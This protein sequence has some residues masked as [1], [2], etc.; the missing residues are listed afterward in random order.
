MRIMAVFDIRSFKYKEEHHFLIDANVWLDV[1]GPIP[2][3]RRSGAYTTAMQ[4]MRV[5]KSKIHLDVLVLSEFIN[6][7]ARILY[8]IELL[9][10]SG[11]SDEEKPKY[12]QFRD[13]PEFKLVAEEIRIVTKDIINM[14]TVCCNPDFNCDKANAFTD[15][16]GR[17]CVDFNDQI[18]ADSCKTKTLLLVTDDGDFQNY[19]EISIL[20][21]NPRAIN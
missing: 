2:R 5:K 12:K 6:R 1:F 15:V 7:Y 17:D 21:A 4:D 11:L 16:F 13:S 18:I 3:S 8:Q 19:D 20:T 14:A 9:K 10:Y